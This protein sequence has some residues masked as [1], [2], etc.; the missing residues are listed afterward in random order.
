M[1][2]TRSHL[3]ADLH[4]TRPRFDRIS[5]AGPQ[6]RQ[7]KTKDERAREGEKR[8]RKGG[9][10]RKERC[11]IP[12]SVSAA[13]A[14]IT[15]SAS[16]RSYAAVCGVRYLSHHPSLPP[17]PSPCALPSLAAAEKGEHG[18][19]VALRLVSPAAEH[20]DIKEGF[21]LPLQKN[22][23][24]GWSPLFKQTPLIS[25]TALNGNKWHYI[26]E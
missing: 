22:E 4:R 26:Y 16:N 11:D 10:A 19:V 21:N 15:N 14:P 7:A 5:H 6:T 1:V 13:D 24:W 12:D 20:E 3:P 23:T 18:E 17:F 9:H 25:N 8:G 2:E